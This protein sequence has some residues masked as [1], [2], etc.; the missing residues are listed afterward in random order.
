MHLNE[1]EKE[2]LSW[3]QSESCDIRKLFEVFVK[4]AT[5]LTPDG[6]SSTQAQ[7]I[8]SSPSY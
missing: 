5:P 8:A 6:W 3:S 2:T 4:R 7:T 1:K